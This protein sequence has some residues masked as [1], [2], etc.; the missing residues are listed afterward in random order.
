MTDHDEKAFCARIADMVRLS[1]RRGMSFTHFLNESQQMSAQQ[2]LK[3]LGCE[4][5]CFFGGAE[6]SVRKILC[7]FSD[8]CRP[9]NSDFPISCVTFKYRPS[10][11]LSH[12]DF[13]GAVM[14]L[15]IKREA[16]GDII[17]GEGMTQMMVIDSVKSTVEGEI[18][19][20]GSAGVSVS[21]DE[22]LVLEVRQLYREI[23]STVSSMRF[24]CVIAAALSVSRSR[25][26]GIISSG[27]AELNYRPVSDTCTLLK[28]GDIFSV[29]KHGKFRVEEIEGVSK[30][31]R[32]HIVVLKYC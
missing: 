15:N 2:E 13:L 28:E 27:A 18:T 10:I 16:V 25:S 21:T 20:I 29:R 1:E 22:P 23:K 24:D 14:A 9:E 32:I 5:C 6:G 3:R 30:K 26:A 17:T 11:K 4:S 31:G 12:R 8:Y 19:K 7:V